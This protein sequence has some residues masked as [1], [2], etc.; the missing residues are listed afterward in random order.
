MQKLVLMSA[1]VLGALA[2]MIGAF[3][4]HALKP[5]LESSGRLDVFETGVKYHFFHTLLLIAIGILMPKLQGGAA[6]WAAIF[7]ILG[8]VIFSGSLYALCIT[9]ITKLGAITPIGG[10]MF[11]LGWL[12]LG[13]AVYKSM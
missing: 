11:I 12:M 4:A 13:F 2:V 6:Q 5:M 8:I 1:S 9:G 3:G 7:T 10:L